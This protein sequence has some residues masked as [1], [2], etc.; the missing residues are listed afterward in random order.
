MRT[1]LLLAALA[2]LFALA[3]LPAA[4][5]DK[6]PKSASDKTADK[7]DKA[8]QTADVAI[9]ATADA[10]LAAFNK[11]DAKAIAALWTAG[12]TLADERGEILKGRAAIEAEYA[13]FFKANPGAKLEIA[14]ASIQ[15]AGPGIA[16]E[17]GT[18]TCSTAKGPPTASRYSA[19][20]VK[21]KD[22]WRMASVRESSVETPSNHGRLAQLDWLIGKWEHRRD[23][24]V[25]QVQFRWIAG[26]SFLQRET[27]AKKN[28]LVVASG[29]QITGF[30]SATGRVKSWS[31]DGTGGHSEG[32]WSKNDAGYLLESRGVMADGSPTSS[33][34]QYIVIAGEK[35]VLGWRSFNRQAGGVEL[36]DVPETVFERV[37]DKK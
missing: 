3:A 2:A 34:E 17:D 6:E 14:I 27:T 31:F 5:K 28:G 9:R 25:V 26:K 20:H 37:A 29:V 1:H 22:G 16:I 15:I 32:V 23:D 7:A 8:D 18:A 19:V 36:A 10:F 24:V 21:E 13:A 33:S 11:G 12:G 35:D 30:D 4:A